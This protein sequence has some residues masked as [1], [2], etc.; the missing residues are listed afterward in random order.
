[1]TM[2]SC[3][4][5]TI[6][7]DF[8]NDWGW[9]ETSA[10]NVIFSSNACVKNVSAVS[11]NEWF[12]TNIEESAISITPHGENK[13]ESPKTAKITINYISN[14]VACER[15]FTVKQ[16]EMDMNICN[17]DNILITEA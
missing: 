16:N 11:S 12:T 15:E 4:D 14:G 9:N 3:D 8:P 2:C 7:S 13:T 17:C 1:M 6:I 10:K 5:F